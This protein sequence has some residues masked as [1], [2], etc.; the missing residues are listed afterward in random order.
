MQNKIRR[1][2]YTMCCAAVMTALLC[3][4][5]QLSI[6]LGPVPFTLQL[7]VCLLLPFLL[8]PCAGGAAMLLY[9]ALGLFGL[10]VFAGGGAGL[11]Y[12][13]RPSFG[14]VLGMALPVPLLS[15]LDGRL[16]ASGTRRILLRASFMLCHIAFTYLA[17][18]SY[19]YTVLNLNGGAISYG[20]CFA[21]GVLPFILPDLAKAAAAL[22]LVSL[23]RPALEKAHLCP[24]SKAQPRSSKPSETD[25]E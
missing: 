24:F 17:G 16:S 1:R 11:G 19:M 15:L 14:F 9:I 2:I 18:A 6:P 3:V 12:V 13:L 23:L 5:A 8:S 10:P 21:A 7:L 25:A 22:L 4:S 20:A